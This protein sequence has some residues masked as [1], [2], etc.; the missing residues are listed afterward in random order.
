[1][2]ERNKIKDLKPLVDAAKADADGP[3]AVRPVLAALHRRQPAGGS[4]Q[5]EAARGP[6]GRG[7][8]DR[9]L[10]RHRERPSRTAGWAASLPAARRGRRAPRLLWSPCMLE[11][12]DAA[13]HLDPHHA[14]I[15]AVALIVA[16]GFEVVNGFHDTANAV[17]TVIY[18][19]TLRPMPAVFFSGFCN[20][21]GVSW[22]EARRSPSASSTSCPWTC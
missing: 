2:I 13:R 4:D 12:F 7:G 9:G 14:V 16:F 8:P 3:E 15:L 18:T 5:G 21:L 19:R 11:L 22:S 6:E 10:I 1:M 20:F 17:T